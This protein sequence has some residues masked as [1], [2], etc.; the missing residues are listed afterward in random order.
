MP[1]SRWHWFIAVP[2]IAAS[3]WILLSAPR[4]PTPAYGYR[5]VN[6]YPHDAN[7]FTQGLLY[8]NGFLF[9]GTGNYGGSGIRKVDLA[10]GRVLQQTPLPSGYFG[11]GI[12]IWQDRLIQLTWTSKIAFAY[13]LQ[14]FRQIGSFVYTTEG[15]GL[16]HDGKR[17]I[18]SDGSSNLYF[19]DPATFQE[20]G[21]IQVT[22]GGSPLKDL[23]ELEFIKGEIWANVWQTERI[24]RI[25]PATGKVVSWIDLEGLRNKTGGER[26]D[27]LNGIAYD[28]KTDRVFV[29]GK[30]WPKLYEIKPVRR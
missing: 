14:T 3:A 22:D 5:I 23:N 21:R 24:A 17:L 12:T 25:S 19:R 11:E 9:E 1:G 28:A 20:I 30:W 7:A 29:T 26:P 15:W 13:D 18:M 16:T 2:A 8:Q 10:S 27:V 4:T 6:T